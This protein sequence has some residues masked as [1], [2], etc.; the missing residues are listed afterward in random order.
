MVAKILRRTT[1]IRTAL[2]LVWESAPRWAVMNILTL[3]VQ[4][5]IPVALLYL[6]KLLVDEITQ[7][8]ET[9]S[10]EQAL[11]QLWPVI[12]LFGGITLVE[13][14]TRIAANLINE[15]QSYAV[16]DYVTNIIHQQSLALDLDYYENSHYHD[17]LHRVQR[18]APTRPPQI[19]NS[20]LQSLRA[21]LSLIGIFA[22][23]AT[24][25]VGLTVL[26]VGAAIPGA[27]IRLRYSRILY[28][29]QRQSA[30][31]ERRVW[32]YNLLI[33]FGNYAKENRLYNL[34]GLFSERYRQLRFKL[35]QERLN[36]IIRRS[37]LDIAGQVFVIAAT[38]LVYW[39]VAHEA[40]VGAITI[41][42]L[43]MYIQGFQRGQ[44]L[45][46]E[47]MSSLTRLYEDSLFWESYSEFM[48]LTPQIYTP[49]NPQPVPS[50]FQEGIVFQD[51]SFQYPNQPQA[52]LKGIDLSIRPGEVVALVGENGA[53]KSTLV[54]LLCR[55]YD[56]TGGTIS[57]D[58]VPLKSF[59]TLKWRKTISVVFQ[60]Y[61]QYLLTARENIWF[62]DV[63]TSPDDDKIMEAARQ[64]EAHE[65]IAKL[66]RGLDTHVGGY[67][68]EG[69]E[70]SVGQWQ[71]IAL[72]RAFMRSQ[73]QI[74]ILD[75]PTSS[76]DVMTEHHVFERFRQI[77]AGKTALLI[78]HRLST[79]RL[80]DRIYVLDG[81]QIVETGNHDSLMRQDGL[82]AN[83]FRTQAHH[84]KMD[85]TV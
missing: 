84:Y 43:V 18:D 75:E 64:S 63:D 80:A 24:F 56:P 69:Q 79:V 53:G 55:L 42:S 50:P 65:V 20:I 23:L 74:V 57:V 10:T 36:I 31:T 28:E 76:L 9:G 25:H 82:Y 17:T 1:L 59:D 7:A 22:L 72:A 40:V 35:L 77:I 81:G 13:T 49:T 3:L 48:A 29:W 47:T 14:I 83:L 66:K 2:G 5:V 73:A 85:E 34:G 51:V 19:V 32:Y 16:S 68:E 30:A 52:V 45:M 11:N 60:D 71:R 44:G 6:M 21:I 54:K 67:F 37:G 62:G 41:G 27:L 70:L 33:I 78:S 12:L 58:G 4:S 8:V 46:Q 26:L 39:L 38:L 15:Y 61:I